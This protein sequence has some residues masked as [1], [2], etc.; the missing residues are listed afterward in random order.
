MEWPLPAEQRFSQD[1]TGATSQKTAF[2]LAT[3]VKASN[4][5]NVEKFS[6]FSRAGM[7]C[8]PSI[9][10]AVVPLYYFCIAFPSKLYLLY[11]IAACSRH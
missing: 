4:L 10:I 6:T 3:S 1:P 8:C 9:G 7:F 11:N 5:T 2:S